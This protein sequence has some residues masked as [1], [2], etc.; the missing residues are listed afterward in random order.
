MS[1]VLTRPPFG[2]W[3]VFVCVFSPMSD[4][5]QCPGFFNPAKLS[6]FIFLGDIL[7]KRSKQ[8]HTQI[9]QDRSPGPF[10][11]RPSPRDDESPKE[12]AHFKSTAFLPGTWGPPR[13]PCPSGPQ[14]I[15]RC[16]FWISPPEVHSPSSR[17]RRGREGWPRRPGSADRVRTWEPGCPHAATR[18]RSRCQVTQEPGQ[19]GP[20]GQSLRTSHP[21]LAF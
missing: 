3:V 11:P 16:A 8:S 17:H 12:P 6:P 18:G 13:S 19:D 10:W 21:S 9:R 15:S 7:R 14:L 2:H 5:W 4:I 20:G 1:A